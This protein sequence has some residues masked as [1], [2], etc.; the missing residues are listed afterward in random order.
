MPQSWLMLRLC[1]SKSGV[2]DRFFLPLFCSSKNYGITVKEEDQ[3]LLIHRPSERQNNQGMVSA[4]AG[5]C[6]LVL[7]ASFSTRQPLGAMRRGRSAVRGAVPSLS[8][9]CSQRYSFSPL[10][11]ELNIQRMS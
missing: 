5:A 8:V 2:A 1:C 4:A 6:Q 7:P 10:S 3:P 11:E 9:S